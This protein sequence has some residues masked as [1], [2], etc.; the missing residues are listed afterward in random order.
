MLSNNIQLRRESYKEGLAPLLI[1]CDYR[2]G[3]A[4]DIP[5][6]LVV[7]DSRSAL[8][9]AMPNKPSGNGEALDRD[10]MAENLDRGWRA[11]VAL[12]V[13]LPCPSMLVRSSS[14]CITTFSRQFP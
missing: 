14:A 13:A 7:D 1:E 10:P 8:L 3:T 9:I 2:S 4:R 11:S 12:I 6:A 5:D